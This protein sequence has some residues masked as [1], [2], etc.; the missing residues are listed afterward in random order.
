MEGFVRNEGERPVFTLQRSVRPGQA[1]SFDEA[2]KVV[3]AKS[4]K[5]PGLAFIKWLRKNVFQDPLWVFYKAEGEKLF[6]EEAAQ[7]ISSDGGKGA[8]INMRRKSEALQKKEN[9]L[10]NIITNPYI[11][12][13]VLIE[14]CKDREVLKKALNLSKHITG[15]EAHMRHLIR[16][17][18]QVY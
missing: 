9:E 11:V 12:S 10:E 1:L 6:T 17:L 3:G 18:E 13:K 8:G 14:R 5:K 4:K 2:Y 16:R 15:K 7:Q